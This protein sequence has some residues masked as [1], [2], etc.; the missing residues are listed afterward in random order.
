MPVRKLGVEDVAVLIASVSDNHATNVLLNYVGLEEVKAFGKSLG[1]RD[2]ALLDYVGGIRG[3]GH[4]P[5]LSVGSGEELSLLMLQI[6]NGVLVSPAVSQ[7]M[8]KWLMVS[9]DLSMVAS[10]FGLD[11]LAHC[12]ADR[13]FLV[14]NKTGTDTGIR[15]D[16][17]C[18]SGESYTLS[19]AVIANWPK[20]RQDLRDSILAGMNSV[21]RSIRAFVS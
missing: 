17:G 2:T 1:F 7:R 6:S 4:A 14:M 10:A 20:E 3:P 16:V 21:G 18:V 8:R 15:A 13:G 12:Y 11:P 9:V 19:Y 5:T